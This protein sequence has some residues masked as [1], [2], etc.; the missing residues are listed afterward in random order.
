MSRDLLRS[1]SSIFGTKL[2]LL[3]VGI[4]STP[5]IVRAIGS[6]GYGNYAH[7][8]SIFS[9]LMVFTKSGIFNGIRKYIVEDRSVDDWHNHVF[10]FYFRTSVLISGVLAIILLSLSQIG[11]FE[12]IFSGDYQ[13][14]FVLL[15]VYLF[16]GQFYSIGRGALM[17][18]GREHHSEPIQMLNSISYAGVGLL[19][20][21]FGFGVDGLLIGH[22]VATGIAGFLSLWLVRNELDF[23]QLIKP[24]SDSVPQKQFLTFNFNSVLLAFLTV[25][26][27]NVDLLLLRPLAGSSETGIYKAALTVAE[28]LWLIPMAIQYTLVHSTSEMWYKDQQ[29][30]ISSI[31]STATRLNLSLLVIMG[32]GL[33]FLADTF[34]PLYY[35]SEFTPAVGA[36]FLLLP[37][38]L[39]LA[40]SRPIFA[41][42]Q[43]KGQLK[44]LVLTTGASAVL[45]LI[46]NI[47]L[48]PKHGMYGAAVAT[49]IGYGSM[50]LFHVVTARF[51]GFNPI[52]DLR[53]VRIGVAG[54]LAAG[55]IFG[56]KYFLP[57]LPALLL[58]P[59][60]GF[61]VYVLASVQMGVVDTPEIEKLQR[62]MPNKLDKVFTLLKNIR[63]GEHPTLHH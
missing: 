45:N 56:L 5:I 53:I 10:S 4:L 43:G 38:V 49:S 11:Q 26:M 14:Y 48:I 46:L 47:I 44:Y 12:N 54:I 24:L 27:Y 3:L 59:P 39:G 18:F 57:P 37:G 42:G 17:G 23:T 51:I 61:V 41:I 29:E 36:L 8:I 40:L 58:V 35:G 19:L 7:L 63:N 31:A 15:A 32:I 55:M 60:I 33:I 52:A 9:L 28:F 34:I 16:L 30:Q 21:Y 25:S 2:G 6:E 50:F 62:H 13:Y 1:F 20:L 22:I